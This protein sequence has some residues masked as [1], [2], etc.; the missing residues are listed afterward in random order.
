MFGQATVREEIYS[1]P[2]ELLDRM[3][4][5]L[6]MD[7]VEGI[8]IRPVGNGYVLAWQEKSKEMDFAT[9]GYDTPQSVN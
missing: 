2:K 9:L 7:I 8:S 1:D 6:T 5:V 3:A 4:K